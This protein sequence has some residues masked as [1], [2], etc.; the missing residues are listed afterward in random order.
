VARPR[1]D[2]LATA[3]E[4]ERRDEELAVA[5]ARLAALGDRVEGLRRRAVELRERLAQI[6]DELGRLEAAAE[7]ARA[8][9]REAAEA[10]A[11]A[12]RLLAEAEAKSRSET[13]QAIELSRGAL[14]RRRRDLEAAEDVLALHAGR[15]EALLAE[16]RGAH[17]E[18][19]R[20]EQEARDVAAELA[21]EPRVAQAASEPPRAGLDGV[22]EWAERAVAALLVVRSGRETEYERTLREAVELASVALGEP[23]AGS[24]ATIR[25]R[26]ENELDA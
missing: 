19:A 8:Q 12:E 1:I 17:D 10:V 2:V 21:S 9:Q 16:E 15:R 13:D 22:S 20:L 18:T 6:P 24:V 23:V 14:A 11:D 5:L 4:L 3:E 26:L 25:R 7:H